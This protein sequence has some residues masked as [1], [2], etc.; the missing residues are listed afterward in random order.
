[1]KIL[2]V[3]TISNTVNH[4][5]IPH[6]QFL[7]EQGNEVGLAFNVDVISEEIKHLGCK[8][9][10]VD[11]QRDPLKKEN[12]RS[13]KKVK[14][15]I[16]NEGY[17]LIHVHTPVAAFI[18]RLACRKIK[19][20]KVLYTAHGFHFFKGAPARNWLIYYP[21]EKIAAKWTDGVI[22]INEED[23]QFAKK[24]KLKS[25]NT[26]Y[27]VNGVGIDL[28]KFI[29]KS[30]VEIPKLRSEYQ[31][32][33]KDFIL[34]T[35][36]ELN[37]GKHQ[38][39]LINAVALLTK[40]I[41]YIR[42]LIVGDGILKEKL[43]KQTRDLGIEKH[44]H[45]LGYRTDIPNLMAISDIAVSTSKREG[46]PVN[47]MEA[48]AIGLPL[49]VTNIRGNRDL[50]ADGINGLVVEKDDIKGCA[51]AIRK[52]YESEGL[53]RTFSRENRQRIIRYSREHVIEELDDIYK[54]F[55]INT[56]EKLNDCFKQ[57]H[58]V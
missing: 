10:E 43:M 37:A 52:L 5:L 53:R 45:F 16:L 3:T 13:I 20:V 28:E 26:V 29:P 49:I 6:I 23:Y 31:F 39:L 4:F 12:Y 55:S 38:D 50:V 7:I 11:F 34:I 21:L 8:I 30:I 40:E 56:E 44:I 33:M 35:V 41:P 42:L 24:F 36:G 9:H 57:T 27:K 22:T 58:S 32:H 1:M 48:M 17:E 15:I 46:L 14:T 47:V 51:D 2:Y 19:S 18:T 54:D 25:S